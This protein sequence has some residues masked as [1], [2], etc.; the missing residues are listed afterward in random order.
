VCV[1]VILKW[2]RASRLLPVPGED[3]DSWQLVF[4]DESVRGAGAAFSPLFRLLPG[5]AP[6][7]RLADRFPTTAERG[8]RWVAD[9][10][11]TFGRLI[12]G[13]VK[14]WAD[15]VIAERQ[16]QHSSAVADE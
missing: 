14:R 5:G 3:L 4:P 8:Y 13:R 16:S 7:A 10:R 9:R 11:S 6:L 2:D 1:A 12:P 15:R